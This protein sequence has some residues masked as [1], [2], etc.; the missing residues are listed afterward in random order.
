MIRD[1][2]DARARTVETTKAHEY[3]RRSLST[4]TRTLVMVLTLELECLT[5][6][7]GASPMHPHD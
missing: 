7:V 6:A 5:G 4:S 2:R 1:P 3:T